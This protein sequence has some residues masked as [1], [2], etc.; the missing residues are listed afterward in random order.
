MVLD[1]D[2]S[3]EEKWSLVLYL[4]PCINSNYRQSEDYKADKRLQHFQKKS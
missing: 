1:A 3:Y 4:T 2:Y